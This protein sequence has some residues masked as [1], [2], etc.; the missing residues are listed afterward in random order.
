M[1]HSI[2]RYLDLHQL[3]IK[4][5][6]SSGLIAILAIDKLVNGSSIGGCRFQEYH[7]LEDAI[8]DAIRL[9][10]AMTMKTL[11]A[12]LDTGGAKSVIIKNSKINA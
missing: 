1:S 10:K 7:S 8:N 12:G 4:V 5:D 11:A 2:Q 3:S 6:K 9:S